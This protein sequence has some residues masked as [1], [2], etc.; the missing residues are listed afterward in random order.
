MT[1]CTDLQ[2]PFFTLIVFDGHQM[3]L[4][5]AWSIQQRETTEMIIDFLRVVKAAALEHKPD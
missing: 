4:P 5:I 2:F 3:G 1:C